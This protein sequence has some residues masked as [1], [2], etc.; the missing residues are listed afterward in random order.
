MHPYYVPLRRDVEQKLNTN[1]KLNIPETTEPAI[2]EPK[3]EVANPVKPSV[4]TVLLNTI[5]NF[6][7]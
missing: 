2:V 6:L 5:K 1:F 4:K 3:P 7:K